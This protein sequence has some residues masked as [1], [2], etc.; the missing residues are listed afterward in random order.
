MSVG[1]F[2]CST[3]S[4]NN[5]QSQVATFEA[6]A[7]NLPVWA[8]HSEKKARPN[9]RVGPPD[10]IAQ[11][12]QVLAIDPRGKQW[13]GSYESGLASYD[14]KELSYNSTEL[15]LAG[16]S[17]R[18]IATNAEGQ[19]WVATDNG[20][21]LVDES[22]FT[23]YNAANGL[24][25]V[26]TRSLLFAQDG[27]LWIGTSDGAYRFDGEKFFYFHLQTPPLTSSEIEH[28]S[29]TINDIVQDGDGNL[30]FATE[31]YGIYKYSGSSMQHYSQ[32]DGLPSNHVQQLL[33]DSRG[34]IW[35]ATTRS[36]S[37]A[38]VYSTGGGLAVLTGDQFETFTKNDGMWNNDIYAL[39]EDDQ[40]R[41]WIGGK[42]IGAV[43]FDGQDFTYYTDPSGY[44]FNEVRSITQDAE[45]NILVGMRGGLY[46]LEN[47]KL[48]HIS[49]SDLGFEGC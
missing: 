12:I 17:I 28:G 14:G 26:D 21:S 25:N 13:I 8:D 29:T 35:A 42:D 24:E 20:L 41:V 48:V 33:V 44:T 6:S 16:N 46:K 15:G 32:K 5:H 43:L 11:M 22:S 31:G 3:P 47:N 23:N 38:F 45:G 10:Q 30:W 19:V 34:L 7:I 39:Y 4:Q 36:N 49:Q 9:C 37:D 2:S 1:L 18:D 40:Q 27:D